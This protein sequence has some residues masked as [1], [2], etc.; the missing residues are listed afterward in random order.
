M[1]GCGVDTE[2]APVGTQFTVAFVVFDMAMPAAKAVLNRTITV[3]PPCSGPQVYCASLNP[4]CGPEPCAL[5]VALQAPQV[6]APPP[7]LG[8]ALRESS[9]VRV[10]ITSTGAISAATIC[11]LPPPINIVVCGVQSNPAVTPAC[12]ITAEAMPAAGQLPQLSVTSSAVTGCSAADFAEGSCTP[13]TPR[14]VQ[15]GNCSA[16]EQAFVYETVDDRG[17]VSRP[18]QV[19]VTLAHMLATSAVQLTL[20]AQAG[21]AAQS[22]AVPANMTD[23]LESALLTC[24]HT[25]AQCAETAQHVVV[26]VAA[27]FVRVGDSNTT[28]QLEGTAMLG[29]VQP[30]GDSSAAVQCLQQCASSLLGAQVAGSKL[31]V[32]EALT[33]ARA[34]ACPVLTDTQ[35]QQQW[36]EA[37]ALQSE[38]SGLKAV[39]EMVRQPQFDAWFNLRALSSRYLCTI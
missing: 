17:I 7:V 33:R 29:T 8:A 2:T 34:A 25:A 28:V 1:A 20:S 3:A 5:R 36:L 24:T 16:S 12:N 19:N 26:L 10:N 14:A 9:S 35:Q 21:A 6:V 37:T 31:L 11:G 23:W 4:Q 22:A 18:L 27:G 13:C 38:G 30:T 32:A 15:A 39:V